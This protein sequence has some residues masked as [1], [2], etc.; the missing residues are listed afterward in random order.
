MD[1]LQHQSIQDLFDLMD[2]DGH[3]QIIF[4]R[5]PSSGLKAIIAIHD[6]TLG[7][8]L[9]GCRMQ[10]YATTE[11]AL[12]DVLK[13]SKGMTYKS[14]IADVDFGGGKMVVI[15]DPK[16]KRPEL[17]RAIGRFLAG[18]KGR[19][20]TGT[21]MG[22]DPEDF[23]HA[24]RESQAFVGLPKCYGG[25]GDTSLPTAHGVYQ[26]IR[27]TL[28]YLYGDDSL[29]GRTF[30]IQGVGKVGGKLANLLLQ[31]GATCYIADIEANRC[32]EIQERDPQRVTICNWDEIHKVACDIF[33]PCAIG[34]VLNYL[35]IPELRCRAV[36][37]SANN[38][39]SREEDGFELQRREI[40]YAPDYLVN[41]G[42]LIQAATELEGG[43]EET[44]IAKTKSIYEGLLEIYRVS[45][46]ENIPT[47][48]AADQLVDRRLNKVADLHRIY[49]GR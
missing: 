29:E 49:S 19:F 5:H 1:S 36:V 45:A 47:C 6:T 32:L 41:A 37:G 9:G 25:S 24:R 38:Q 21:D 17:F 46:Q 40:W 42:G 12:Q 44:V 11:E 23:V 27:A 13:L 34:G 28:K 7:P 15:G 30:A 14:A 39:L 43:T 4:C 10:D 3:E 22:T 33:A 31:E 18:F 16:E 8:A 20:Y 26:G 35:T 48:Q 2:E